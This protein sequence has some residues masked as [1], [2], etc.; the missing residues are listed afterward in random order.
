MARGLRKDAVIFQRL[1]MVYFSQLRFG[2]MATS[3]SSAILAY[4]ATDSVVGALAWT[5]MIVALLQ[6]G[7]FAL[8]L[9][10]IYP[11]DTS[12]RAKAGHDAIGMKVQL[13]VRLMSLIAIAILTTLAM[14]EMTR[15]DDDDAYFDCV[16]DKAQAIMKTQ[17]RK[18]AA[19]ALKKAYR[20]C[21]PL[22]R[23]K[24]ADIGREVPLPELAPRLY[25]LTNS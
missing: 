7:S 24:E 3:G 13:P 18:D 2:M 17:T 20:V 12:K 8:L 4:F 11:P 21:Q 16:L 5:A 1:A 6:T 19:A 25:V 23:P 15:A 9:R 10:P 22:E 14:T